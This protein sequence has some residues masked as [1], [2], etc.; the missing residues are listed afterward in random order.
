[1][2]RANAK[3]D[4]LLPSTNPKFASFVSALPS[5][6][7]PVPLDWLL[8]FPHASTIYTSLANFEKVDHIYYKRYLLQHSDGGNNAL[9]FCV[10]TVT[11]LSEEE[12]RTSGDKSLPPR[13]AYM[14][15]VEIAAI[16]DDQPG[17]LVLLLHGLAGGSHESYI[18]AS[19]SAIFRRFPADAETKLDVV[20][21]NARGCARS[22]VT[23][24]NY[25]NAMQ[26]DDLGAAVSF[27]KG[28]FPNKKVIAVGYSLGA[29]ILCHYLSK[30]HDTIDL[31]ISVSNPWALKVSND[32]LES[33][34]LGRIYSQKMAAGL[35][36]LFERHA[37][38]LTQHKGITKSEVMH[39]RSLRAFDDAFTAR[40]FGFGSAQEYYVTASSKFQVPKIQSPL[41]ILNSSDDPMA[42][43]HVLPYEQVQQNKYTAMIVSSLGGHIGWYCPGGKRWFAELI[44]D[45]IEAVA[46]DKLQ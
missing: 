21:F 10:R 39:A 30:V 38:L 23:S 45:A 36:K 4:L 34:W 6:Q 37:T 25:W 1:M 7:S 17:I 33:Y 9:D 5:A 19:I 44:V 28:K 14:K 16:G 42:S 27:L 20:A 31:A 3:L 32:E 46:Q 11:D 43:E 35:Q 29:N 40:V 26:T 13:T 18:R 8:S 2:L 41:L 15:D 22:E 12:Y 24:K